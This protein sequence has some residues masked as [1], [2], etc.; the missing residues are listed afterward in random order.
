[1]DLEKRQ[2]HWRQLGF[3]VYEDYLVSIDPLGQVKEMVAQHEN[4]EMETCCRIADAAGL[5]R[6]AGIERTRRGAGWGRKVEKLCGP[7]KGHRS[8]P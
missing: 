7:C 1:M 5:G 3:D 4:T 8:S 6:G 2:L